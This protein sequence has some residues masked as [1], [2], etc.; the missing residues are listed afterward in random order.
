[1]NPHD[2]VALL[3]GPYRA[4]ALGKGDRAFCLFRDCEVVVTSWTDAPISWPR[5]RSVDHRR[6]APSLLVDEELVRAV[7][8]ESAAAVV[9][10][11]RVSAFV[12]WRWR[13][14]FAVTKTNNR[15]SNR[16][17][18]AAAADGAEAIKAR[19]WSEEERE[20]RRENALKNN[21]AQH[22]R[23][24]YRDENWTGEEI[25]LLGQL[26]DTKVARKTGRTQS[27]VRQKREELG[28][29]NP[30]SWRWTAEELAFLGTIPD[31]E[32]ARM[33]GRSEHSVTQKRW[34]LGIPCVRRAEA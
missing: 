2:R 12:V 28:I 18:R 33:L 7:R 29:P 13:R 32:V 9:H 31:A 14:A 34:K 8:S 3:H 30:T 17:V 21:L 22:L 5:C 26:P 19:E 25:A 6:S 1:M 15:G 4:P 16:L 11:W 27:A 23:M 10:W 20:V 24:A